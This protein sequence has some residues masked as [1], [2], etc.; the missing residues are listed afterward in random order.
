MTK[1]WNAVASMTS[2][3]PPLRSPAR[4]AGTEGDTE[5]TTAVAEDE[6]EGEQG[7]E[8]PAGRH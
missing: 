2:L 1:R 6:E 7:A 5:E 4:K 3:A 8:G